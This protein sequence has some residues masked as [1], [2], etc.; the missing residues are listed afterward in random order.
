M[1]SCARG[2]TSLSLGEWIRSGRVSVRRVLVCFLLGASAL[3]AQ[4]NE[5]ELR[6]K[7]TDP[8]GLGVQTTVEITSKAN[9][10]HRTFATDAE[11]KVDAKRLAFGIYRIEI[12][13]PGFVAVSENVEIQSALPLDHAIQLKLSAV[14]SSVTVTE[15]NTLIDPDQAGNINRIGSEQIQTRLTSLPGR[16]LQDLVNTQ[17]GWSF[18]GNAVLHPRES[19]YQTQLVIDGIPLTDNR[20]PSFA[21][22]IGADDI[23]SI[24][25]YTAGFP[26]EYGRKMGGVIEINTLEDS[27][28]GFHAQTVL[29]GGSYD[30]AGIS[31]R[32]Q[33]VEGRNTFG[34]SASGAMTSHYL[35]PVVPENYTNNGTASGFAGSYERDV[36]THDRIGLIVRHEFSRFNIPNEYVQQTAGQ[37]QDGNNAETMGIV[38]YQHI[39]SADA[40]ADLRGMVRDTSNGL[41]SNAESTPVIAFLAN[42]LREGYFKGSIAVHHG[43]QEWKVGVESD[44]IFLH[45]NFNY[46]ITNASQFPAGTPAAFRFL[47]A[48]PDLEQSAFAQDMIRLGSWTVSAGLRWD[49]YQLLVNQNAV[50]PRLA[51]AY[52]NHTANLVLHVSYDRIFQTPSFENILLSSSPEVV[53]LSPNVLRLPVEPSH[54]NYFEVGATKVVHRKLK[55][56]TNY[57]RRYVNDF[58]DDDQLLNTG[59]SFPIAFRKALIY[60]MEEKISLP[61]WRGLSGLLSY[62]YMVGNDWLPVTGGLFLGDEATAA[63]TQ[64]SGHLPISQDQRNT[65]R[66]Q[67]RYQIISRL[68]ISGGAE[69]DSGLPF[70]Y[71]GTEAEA[72]AD[73]GPAVVSRIDFTRG[74]IRP[75]LSID[76]SMGVDIYKSDRWK[77]RLQAD[78]ENLNDRL[79]IID[80]NGLF[81]GNAIGPARSFALRLATDF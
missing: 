78:G 73:Y 30:S 8:S 59:V 10:Y 4:S 63:L 56:D 58:A 21:P 53:S 47:G 2:T 70:E 71:E 67:A 54:G 28:P 48:R 16:S 39:F 64:V 34:A 32:T 36:T 1:A 68:W 65:V 29:T 33:Y 11:G 35:N 43:I 37:R 40:V 77:M 18:E 62:S 38:S 66:F 55:M 79:N 45:E 9:E 80:F 42:S 6:L 81:S 25:I 31:T 60:G 57:F 52:F 46:M 7:V 61:E 41:T 15:E 75:A 5:G 19:E 20:S 23:Q 72:L 14:S 12:R 27:H 74:R 76:L 26:A 69:Y 44:S 17:P 13:Q 3:C 49:H 22:E 51:A 50:S 24:G